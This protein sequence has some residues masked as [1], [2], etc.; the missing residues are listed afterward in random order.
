MSTRSLVFF[1]TALFLISVVLITGASAQTNTFPAS[2]SVGIGTPTPAGKLEVKA[3]SGVDLVSFFTSVGAG[4]YLEIGPSGTTAE[5]SSDSSGNFSLSHYGVAGGT[6]RSLRTGAVGNTLVLNSGNVG[7]GT[8]SPQTL[9]HVQNVNGGSLIRLQKTA[10]TAGAYDL[11]IAANGDFL[12]DNAGISRLLTVTSSGNVGIGTTSPGS[13][14]LAVNGTI[15]AK[16]VIVDTVWSDYVFKPDYNLASL[17]EVEGAIK[18]EGHL[19]GIPSAAE[20]AEHGIS[21]GDMQ[22]KLLAKVEELTLHLIAQEKAIA[23]VRAENVELRHQVTE[24][25]VSNR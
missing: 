24:L 20:V 9:L 12:I 10:A 22:S 16:E 1:P 6:F 21:M 8:A 11:G 4:S 23:A 2:G 18:R 5:L 15:R 19:P 7:I 25:R 17:S 13:Y 14:K 3:A